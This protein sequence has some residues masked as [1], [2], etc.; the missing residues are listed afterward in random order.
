MKILITAYAINPYKGSE[1]GTGWNIVKGVAKEHKV[2]LI[3]RKNNIPHL[4]QFKEE[5]G[6]PVFENIEYH[7]YDLKDWVL[8]LKK[9][10]GQRGYVLYYYLWQYF[11]YRFIKAKDFEFELTHSLNFHSDSQ[12]NFLWKLG[13]KTV[14]G[15]IGHHPPVP[16]QYVYKSYG[17][18]TLLI[19]RAR[20]AVKWFFRNMD[21]FFRAAI[22]NSDEI[23]VINSRVPKVIHADPK[24]VSLIPAVASEWIPLNVS[25]KN[26]KVFN[27]ICVGRLNYIKGFDIA[28]RSFASF[29]NNLQA[30]KRKEVR[31][32]ILGSGEEMDNLQKLSYELGIQQYV[33]WQQWIDKSLMNRFYAKADV[34]L[35]PSHEGAGMVVPEAMSHGV[36][37]IC[38]DNYGP[39]ELAAESALKI[40]Y[41][42]Y[43]RSVSDFADALDLL[44][45][46][47]ELLNYYAVKTRERF[48]RELNWD[49]KIKSIL[50]LYKTTLS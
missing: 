6:D 14:W 13:K 35:F 18:K 25:K 26:K 27:V 44:F 42:N 48:E 37:V 19:D 33:N 34:F 1:D 31:L 10:S 17:S 36:P 9:R 2:I 49:V 32:T 24:K 4:D 50:N 38:F 28:L 11:V 43:V 45:T 30:E 40:P 5:S 46:D 29:V 15:P 8:D 23:I 47:R 12:P 16:K 22:K 39:G 21:P 7:G 41:T 3:T 20:N